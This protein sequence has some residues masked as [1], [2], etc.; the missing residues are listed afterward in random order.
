MGFGRIWPRGTVCQCR[1]HNLKGAATSLSSDTPQAAVCPFC[2]AIWPLVGSYQNSLNPSKA[3][4]QLY[5]LT[6]RNEKHSTSKVLGAG[7]K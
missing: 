1:G 2:G 4:V 7:E 6:L 5:S 3:T